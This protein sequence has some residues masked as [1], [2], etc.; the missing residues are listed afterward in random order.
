MDIATQTKPSLVILTGAGISAESGLKTFRADDGLWR[1]RNVADVASPD[2]FKRDPKLVQR[3]YNERRS[4]LPDV[5]PNQAHYALAELE[6]AWP[7][8]FLLVTQNVDDLH[9]RAGNEALLHMHGELLKARCLACHRVLHWHNDILPDSVCLSCGSKGLLRPHVVWF[10]EFP[11]HMKEIISALVDC[12][13]FVS[14]GTSGNVSP[15]AD[16]VHFV[17]PG[18]N[19]IEFNLESNV[20]SGV[21]KEAHLGPATETVPAWVR[22]MISRPLRGCC[23]A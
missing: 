20:A 9:D 4:Q 15:A 10:G 6:R 19:T 23:V 12:D 1:N 21:F 17:S 14:I 18:C 7:G 11:L 22:Q 5:S 2:G 16:F 8:P 13:Y 3:F